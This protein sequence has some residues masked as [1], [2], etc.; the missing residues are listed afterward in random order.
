M[1]TQNENGSAIANEKKIVDAI[2]NVLAG[3]RDWDGGRKEREI[4][5]QAENNNN[6]QITEEMK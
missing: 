2:G 6:N 5:K 3:V 4:A 1:R